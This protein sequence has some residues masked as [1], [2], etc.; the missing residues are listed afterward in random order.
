MMWT[1]GRFQLWGLIAFQPHIISSTDTTGAGTSTFSIH[2][3]PFDKWT[4][5]VSSKA[6]LRIYV[7]HKRW[8][9]HQIY[10]IKNFIHTKNVKD[11]ISKFE[12]T[13]QDRVSNNNNN[14]MGNCNRN[15]IFQW[16]G[17]ILSFSLGH[18]SYTNWVMKYTCCARIIFNFS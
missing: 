11:L 18:Q 1:S 13:Q 2:L 3:K 8:S 14:M 4:Q 15:Q 17:A 16:A 10:I 12:S 9:L 5:H 6:L 7:C